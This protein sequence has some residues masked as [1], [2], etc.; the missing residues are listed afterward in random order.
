[1]TLSS[2]MVGN[3]PALLTF[4]ACMIVLLGIFAGHLRHALSQAPA[5]RNAY[6][7][8]TVLGAAFHAGIF[9]RPSI[10]GVPGRAYLHLH[11]WYWPLPRP[12]QPVLAFRPHGHLSFGAFHVVPGDVPRHLH[13]R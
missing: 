13:P 2:D 11:H 3:V 1:M 9:F 10:A 8:W 5:F 7:A 12:P 4:A 6:L